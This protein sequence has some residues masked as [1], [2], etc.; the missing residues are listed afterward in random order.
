MF[1][2]TPMAISNQTVVPM[3]S[4]RDGLAALAWLAEAF[5]FVRGAGE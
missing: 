3:L 4:Y 1:E 2:E 5:G